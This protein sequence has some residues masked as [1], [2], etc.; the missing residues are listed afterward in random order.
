MSPK[1]SRSPAAPSRNL[2][3]CYRVAVKV[4]DSYGHVEFGPA[5]IAASAGLAADSGPARSLVSD[6]KQYGLIEKR[7]AGC[8]SISQ[9][10][11][12]MA[13]MEEGSAEFKAAAYSL[14]KNPRVFL[15]VLSACRDKLPDETGLA[16]NLRSTQQFN[17]AKAQSTAKALADSLDWAGIL[18]SKRNI[19]EPR[20][21]TPNPDEERASDPKM[22][23]EDE[24]ETD[25]DDGPSAG[26]LTLDI[27]LPGGRVAR[28]K[29]PQDLTAEEAVKIGKVL[30][31]ISE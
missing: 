4:Y 24:P 20:V 17:Q 1:G 23:L 21:A 9:A 22:T 29:Y 13:A 5:E 2:E 11:K 3:T 25:P 30:A 10:T 14:V 15:D 6:L 26:T 8:F 16:N 19:L 18:D 28:V 31:A 27:P 12:N 7:G